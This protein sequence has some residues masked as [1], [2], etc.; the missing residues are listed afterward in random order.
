MIDSG[1]KSIYQ[2]ILREIKLRDKKD[3]TRKISPLVI[4]K[5]IVIDNNGS[6]KI[7]NQISFFGKYRHESRI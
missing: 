6:L 5:G 1:E 3:K 4:P 7:H 2:K